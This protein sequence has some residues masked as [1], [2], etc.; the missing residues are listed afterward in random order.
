MCAM[1]GV[2]T[3]EGVVAMATCRREIARLC[4]CSRHRKK[5]RRGKD[6][7]NRNATWFYR[8]LPTS[9]PTIDQSCRVK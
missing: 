6:A 4:R 8:F 3:Y 2:Q 1:V 9:D 5:E 7:A